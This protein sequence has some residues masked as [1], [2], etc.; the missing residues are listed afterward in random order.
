MAIALCIAALLTIAGVAFY[1]HSRARRSPSLKLG[2]DRDPYRRYLGLEG[3]AEESVR[4]RQKSDSHPEESLLE[5]AQRKGYSCMQLTA[6]EYSTRIPNVNGNGSGCLN[7]CAGVHWKDGNLD[8][9]CRDCGTA[10]FP[11]AVWRRSTD[12]SGYYCFN[13][14]QGY[15]HDDHDG[16]IRLAADNL[17]NR[18][19]QEPWSFAPLYIKPLTSGD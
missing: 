9:V 8:T 19:A 7:F 12:L 1:K 2:S 10:Q 14:G 5:L 13:C 17:I 6:H 11:M 4:A 16:W 18:L 3:N 15:V